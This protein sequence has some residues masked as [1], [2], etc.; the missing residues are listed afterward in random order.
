MRWRV[1]RAVERP[2][3]CPSV[4]CNL[5][6]EGWHQWLGAA[7]RGYTEHLHWMT[8]FVTLFQWRKHDFSGLRSDSSTLDR[9]RSKFRKMR[10]QLKPCSDLKTRTK[11]RPRTRMNIADYHAFAISHIA[12][13][14]FELASTYEDASIPYLV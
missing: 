12:A 8:L 14:S 7:R 6:S 3:P 2:S 10:H 9:L 5:R 4:R 13:Y 1:I 11:P